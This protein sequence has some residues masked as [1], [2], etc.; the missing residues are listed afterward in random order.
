MSVSPTKID[1]KLDRLA[2]AEAAAAEAYGPGRRVAV[3]VPLPVGTNTGGRYDYWLPDSVLGAGSIEV[4]TYI[5][6]PVGK[7]LLPAV[8]WDPTPEAMAGDG[9]AP[10][11]GKKP[12]KITLKA[13]ERV[14]DLPAMPAINREMITWMAGYY[15]AAAGSVAKM[16]LNTPS[17]LETPPPTTAY[18][19]VETLPADLR[20]TPARKRVLAAFAEMP[21]MTGRELADAAGCGV[22]V[23]AGLAEAGGLR[24]VSLPSLPPREGRP[25]LSLPGPVLS[26][27]QDASAKRLVAE[28]EDGGG[29]I[30]VLDGVT[31]A[32][33]T[34][35]YLEAVVAALAKGQQVLVLLP[36]I[37]LSAQWLDR[38]ARRFGATPTLWNSDLTPAQR[39]DTWRNVALNR[40]D[41]VVGARSAL[42][43]PFSNLGLI[44]V[45]EEHDASYKQDDRVAYN[46]RDM[47]IVRGRLADH[48]V[49]LASAT[50]SMET[51]VNMAE[52]RFE[53]LVLPER[54]GTA[55][56]P[57][58]QLVDLT[59]TPPEKP[60]EA[61]FEG[62]GPAWLA[63]PLV[64]AIGET[65]AA[66]EQTLLFLNRRGYA[67]LTLCQSCGHRWRCPNCTAW[68]VEH[69]LAYRMQCHHCGYQTPLPPHCPECGAEDSI[70]ACGPGVERV[71]EEV[72]RRFP[73]ARMGLLTSDSLTGPMAMRDFVA[74]IQTKSLDIIIGTQI[75]AKGH[76]F[77]G[78]TLV[79]IIDADMG[80]GGGDIRAPE[81]SFQLLQQVA[82]RAGRGDRPG[83][84]LVQTRLP[85]EPVLQALVA[86]DRDGFMEAVESDRR[87]HGMPPFG[88]LAALIISDT[89]PG[90]LD[91]AA[92]MLAR[93][94]PKV[95]GVMV[96]GPAPAA[97]AMLRGRHRQRFLIKGGRNAVLAR[98]I[99]PWLAAV[100][101][102]SQ[103][104]VQIDIDPY[105]FL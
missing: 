61:G 68:L 12:R 27:D 67:P 59:K 47:A 21:V 88:R 9:K 18:E 38:F 66:G 82:G 83:R 56:L 45:D 33:K 19:L 20:M 3:L 30:A 7:R 64:D 90:R 74:K 17:A 78:L 1:D 103:T 53:A 97:L 91:H 62:M 2:A 41:V 58:I 31:G 16:F 10:K 75:L 23:V 71:A 22:S 11:S 60:E 24:A 94:A 26:A 6:V 44:I 76:H 101:L 96:L 36:E 8:I 48:P 32:G 104:R 69:R 79:G 93:T 14:F 102:P 35:V 72:Q 46:A 95:D 100:K 42:F 89:D 105:S 40:V 55:E 81:R 70:I 43:L 86:Q 15:A 98:L 77:P 99:E 37:S 52:D 80:L 4:G 85:N 87:L 13:V 5:E 29:H 51:V 84:V 63:P 54:H 57:D 92:A 39:R 73:E 65:L 34:E 25:D 49:V 28:V 50:P